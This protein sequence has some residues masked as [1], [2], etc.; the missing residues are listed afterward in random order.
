MQAA[1]NHPDFLT[2]K[3]QRKA[4]VQAI[5]QDEQQTLQHLYE[6]KLKSRATGV[7]TSNNDT[8]KQ[9]I[10]ELNTR[11]K[12]FQDTGKAVHASALQEVEQER[13]VA[14]EVESVRQVK[15]PHH[16]AAYSFPGLNASL[17]AFARTG[18]LPPDSHYF[19]HIFHALSRTGIGRK[20]KVSS[21][22]TKS[23]LLETVEFSRT[24]KLQG[25]LSNDNFIVSGLKPTPIIVADK[26]CSAPST[27]FSGA[28]P[29][30]LPSSLSLRKQKL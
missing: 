3:S 12:A 1:I 4:Y 22:A 29:L 13:E 19:N 18:R 9:F 17:E 28:L 27:G 10:S 26:T 20:F 14:F 30:K 7:Q 16:Y 21:K 24:I 5:K 8:L 6:P 11:R 15:K 2:D 25:E 23:K